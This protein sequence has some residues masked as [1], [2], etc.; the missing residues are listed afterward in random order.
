[1]LI[2]IDYDETFTSD[3]EVWTAVIKLLQAAGHKIVCATLRRESESNRLALKADLPDGVAIYFCYGSQKRPALEA[4]G[5]FVNIWID[6]CPSS[7][8]ALKS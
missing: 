2:A 5:I 8:E 4:K 3:R 7:I 6:D 1:M